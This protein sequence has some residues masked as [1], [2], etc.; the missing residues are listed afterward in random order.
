MLVHIIELK[1]L[2]EIVP[3][4]VAL[5]K[6]FCKTNQISV[7]NAIRE[8]ATGEGDLL[9][10][11]GLEALRTIFDRMNK[12]FVS[13]T[14]KDGFSLALEPHFNDEEMESEGPYIRV[15]HTVVLSPAAESIFKFLKKKDLT[16]HKSKQEWAEEQEITGL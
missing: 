6:Q 7:D 8:L 4:E 15:A 16:V 13:R 14:T 5:F 9:D 1:K 2:A 12:A 3:D 10:L 11:V